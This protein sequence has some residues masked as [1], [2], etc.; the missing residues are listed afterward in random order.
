MR[1]PFGVVRPLRGAFM[2]LPFFDKTEPDHRERADIC[3]QVISDMNDLQWDASG[4]AFTIEKH[5]DCPVINMLACRGE[6]WNLGGLIERG[7]E[8]TDYA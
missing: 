8:R 2:D 4:R 5:V 3:M 7:G 1:L 6:A